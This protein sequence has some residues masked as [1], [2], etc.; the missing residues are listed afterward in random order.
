[1]ARQTKG[2]Q[3]V[4]EVLRYCWGHTDNKQEEETLLWIAEHLA[5]ALRA[6]YVFPNGKRQWTVD[7]TGETLLV[8]TEPK[9]A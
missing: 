9:R 6:R 4:D 1:M 2:A 7:G 5:T 8:R 3:R